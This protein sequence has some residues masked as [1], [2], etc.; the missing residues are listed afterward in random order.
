MYIEAAVIRIPP[1]SVG[2][3]R[4]AHGWGRWYLAV[5]PSELLGLSP[6]PFTLCFRCHQ[7]R[8]HI[9]GEVDDAGDQERSGS[10]GKNSHSV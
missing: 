9:R 3:H 7:N 2:P 6:H 8:R 10:G 5:L 4:A 1:E